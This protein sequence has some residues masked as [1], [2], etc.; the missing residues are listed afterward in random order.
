MLR[1][2]TIVIP[3]AGKPWQKI[4]KIFP[5]KSGE[6]FETFCHIFWSHP[7]LRATGP[8]PPPGATG[9]ERRHPSTP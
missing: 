3:P 1:Y 5:Q 7:D 4:S 9:A 8:T 2:E 6:I